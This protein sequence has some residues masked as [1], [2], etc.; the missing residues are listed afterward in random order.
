MDHLAVHRGGTSSSSRLPTFE[1]NDT[2]KYMH[3]SDLRMGDFRWTFHS[4]PHDSPLRVSAGKASRH[5]PIL[6]H[7]IVPATEAGKE[8]GPWRI[9]RMTLVVAERCVRIK[10]IARQEGIL[11]LGGDQWR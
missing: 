2:K 6:A 8:G 5:S 1:L 11:R 3:D 4:P 9:V 7:E 10:Y